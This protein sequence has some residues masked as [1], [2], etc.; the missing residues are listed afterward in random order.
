MDISLDLYKLW[1]D[2]NILK[3][4]R[5]QSMG[6]NYKVTKPKDRNYVLVLLNLVLY[7]AGKQ[8]T[9]LKCALNLNFICNKKVLV[10][11]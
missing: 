10:K 4:F 11:H 7:T 5:K 6:C 8:Y 2:L 9:Q 3:E 1:R